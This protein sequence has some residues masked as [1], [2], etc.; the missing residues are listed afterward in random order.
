MLAAYFRLKLYRQFS[1]LNSTGVFPVFLKYLL[2]YWG[3]PKPNC[4]IL[5]FRYL[6][7]TFN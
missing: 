6:L 3:Y 1:L 5:A 4:F 2:K 7:Y